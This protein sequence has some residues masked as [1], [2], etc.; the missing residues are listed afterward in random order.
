[1]LIRGAVL[2][3][4]A[5]SRAVR[6]WGA[7]A[8]PLEWPGRAGPGL[9]GGG[10]GGLAL[11]PVLLAPGGGGRKGPARKMPS[12]TGRALCPEGLS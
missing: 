3:E 11:G 12:E 5:R 8:L 7:P 9:E 2:R 10:R 6:G 4:G 1:M